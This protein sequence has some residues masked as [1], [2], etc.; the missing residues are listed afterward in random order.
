MTVALTMTM[1]ITLKMANAILLAHVKA[2]V[3][4]TAVMNWTTSFT[5]H[6]LR[7]TLISTTTLPPST[8]S[9]LRTSTN[10]GMVAPTEFEIVYTHPYIN[11]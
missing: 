9:G 5:R 1:S 3:T 4:T 2:A 10:G 6:S 11:S 7:S 8:T